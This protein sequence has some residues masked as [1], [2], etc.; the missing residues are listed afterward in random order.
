VASSPA[1]RVP[2]ATITDLD[3]RLEGA[4]VALQWSP[5]GTDTLGR[6]ESVSHYDVFRSTDAYFAP[7]PMSLLGQTGDTTWVD[8]AVAGGDTSHFYLVRT[9]DEAGN[10]SAGSNRQGAWGYPTVP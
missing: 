5:V 8:Q 4:D 2:P 7:G 9:V 10:S 1:D 6:L 3:A